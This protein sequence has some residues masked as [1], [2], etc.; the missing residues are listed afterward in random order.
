[1]YIETLSVK[2]D[3]KVVLRWCF[4]RDRG[5]IEKR[6]LPCIS[7]CIFKA[8]LSIS[9]QTVQQTLLFLELPALDTLHLI[10]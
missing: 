9:P 3:W 5:G 2:I 4:V 6:V 10:A 8:K 1:M 7:T